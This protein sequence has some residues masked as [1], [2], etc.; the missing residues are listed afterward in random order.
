MIFQSFQPRCSSRS[1]STAEIAVT[2]GSRHYLKLSTLLPTFVDR[3]TTAA[4][5]PRR[6]R[7]ASTRPSNPRKIRET[8]ARSSV[9]ER[10]LHTREVAGSKPAVPMVRVW[11]SEYPAAMGRGSRG[12]F[13]WPGVL[14][15]AIAVLPASA[16]AAQPGGYVHFGQAKRE[17]RRYAVMVCPHGTCPSRVHDCRRVSARRVDCP[18]QTLVNNEDIAV[19]GESEVP[20]NEICSWN[21]VATP[22]HG[23]STRLRLQTRHFRCRGTTLRHLPP[24]TP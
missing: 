13:G 11:S 3:C 21:G 10:S 19:E 24:L 12:R 4:A 15:L 17:L 2:T 7:A 23:S 14:L 1:S 20:E 6:E 9:G 22:F 8:R 16:L 5:A 18:S